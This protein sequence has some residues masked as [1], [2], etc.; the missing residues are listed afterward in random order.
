MHN[1]DQRQ[2]H[3]EHPERYNTYGKEPVIPHE[4][5]STAVRPSQSITES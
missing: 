5:S 3:G 1:Y 4:V 2:R